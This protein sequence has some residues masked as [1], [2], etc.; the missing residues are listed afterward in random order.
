MLNR[1]S[2]EHTTYNLQYFALSHCLVVLLAKVVGA[3]SL[4]VW[5]S[6]ESDNTSAFVIVS[7]L[8]SNH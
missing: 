5:G 2:S 4:T 1:R 6:E 3:L 8:L 7:I